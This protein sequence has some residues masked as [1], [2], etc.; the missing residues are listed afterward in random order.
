MNY[1]N[2]YGDNRSI[3]KALHEMKMGETF[4]IDK[5]DRKRVS[6]C[7]INSFGKGVF[8]TKSIIDEEGVA[9]VSISKLKAEVSKRLPKVKT[10]VDGDIVGVLRVVGSEAFLSCL[11]M[12]DLIFH[13]EVTEI[14]LKRSQSFC[15]EH[16]IA[17]NY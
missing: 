11:K 3:A 5:E 2:I 10:F 13:F 8:A 16:G 12:D 7:I 17:L 15:A 9:V 4:K 6:S 14:I 1:L